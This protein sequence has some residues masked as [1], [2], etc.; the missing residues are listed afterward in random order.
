[1]RE[2]LRENGDG[3]MRKDLPRLRP[4]LPKHVGDVNGLS[5]I[6]KRLGLN[7]N[8]ANSVRSVIGGAGA[9]QAQDAVFA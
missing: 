2:E 7:L 8:D 3:R 4:K 6:A 1:M 9:T 5:R